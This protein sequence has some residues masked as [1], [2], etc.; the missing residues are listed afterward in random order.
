MA[1]KKVYQM[2]V[3]ALGAG[4]IL[5]VSRPDGSD[6]GKADLTALSA[7]VHGVNGALYASASHTHV[8]ADITDFPVLADVAT[9]GDYNDLASLP[10]LFS[11]AYADLSGKPT[12]GDL[13]ALDTITATLV[14]DF[15][16]AADARVAVAVGVSVQAYNA[17]LDEYAAVNPTAAG[18][19]LLDDADTTAQRATL[20]LA[21]GT[22]VQAYSANLGALA[23]LSTTD[24]IY[25][26]SA[27][28]TWT[29]VTI[30]SGLSFTTGTLSA[31]G[32]AGSGAI[33][34]SGLTM[35][36]AR[37]LGRT[38][39]STGAIE[40]LTAGTGLVLSGGSLV[41]DTGTSG[42][43]VPLLNGANTHSGLTTFSAGA[44]IT[45]AAAPSTTAVGYL[46][47]PQNI[48]LDSGNVTL[49]LTDCGKHIY[50]TDANARDLTI[51]ANGSIA[52]PVGTVIAGVNESGAGVVTL[53]IT[54]DTLRWG[55]S[56]GQRT[57]AAN[58]S[59]SLL[60]V[61]ATVWRL[62]GDGIT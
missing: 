43:K 29:A 8:V 31:T 4:D 21:I 56:T 55:S 15:S 47:A 2:D 5:Y 41:V 25:Y 58:A 10:A 57:I 23:A 49:A 7:I 35:A 61:A 48:G 45:P 36:T 50:H 22:D 40:E 26:L 18:L 12:L 19:A 16:T 17:N 59:F 13:A 54:T 42:A 37:I 6:D 60:K 52:F 3:L 53:K 32:F 38:T 28:N 34:G 46:G 27:A 14:T 51:P 39:G 33:T 62:T 9:S 24:K 11:G 20:G 44:D 1:D 30:G